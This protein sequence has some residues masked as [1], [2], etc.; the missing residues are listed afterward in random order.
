MENQLQ[1]IQ[2]HIDDRFNRIEAML[3]DVASQGI[4]NNRNLARF[5]E[6]LKT[7]AD[8]FTRNDKQHEEFYKKINDLEK[9]SDTID[10][11]LLI[12]KILIVPLILGVVLALIR[13]VI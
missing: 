10:G 4:D 6:R 2:K 13:T 1:L 9:K 5:E 7:G 3:A 12:L 8:N 11:G